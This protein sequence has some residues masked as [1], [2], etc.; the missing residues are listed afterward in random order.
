MQLLCRG[1]SWAPA[2]ASALPGGLGSAGLRPQGGWEVGLGKDAG[3]AAYLT[4]AVRTAW[5]TR[6][7][8]QP[9]KRHPTSR[10]GGA[11]PSQVRAPGRLGP[12][13]SWGLGDSDPGVK[14]AGPLSGPHFSQAAFCPLDTVAQMRGCPGALVTES[15]LFTSFCSAGLTAQFSWRPN[16]LPPEHCDPPARGPSCSLKTHPTCDALHA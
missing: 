2:P 3:Q 13:V 12:N 15:Y 6:P 16:R 1:P 9:H 7:Q 14:E 8:A 11:S 10:G 5:G 4:G